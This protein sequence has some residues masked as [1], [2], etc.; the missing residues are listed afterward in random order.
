MLDTLEKAGAIR[1]ISANQ[2]E[3]FLAISDR[4]MESLICCILRA[5]LPKILKDIE[6]GKYTLDEIL[7]N[8]V[9]VMLFLMAYGIASFYEET[10]EILLYKP[11]GCAPPDTKTKARIAEK[12]EACRPLIRNAFERITKD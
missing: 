4:V 10:G 7:E 9:I 12:I 5:Q 2:Y 6:S 3:E 1:T 11:V 8:H